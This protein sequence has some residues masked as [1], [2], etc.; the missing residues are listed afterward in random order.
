MKSLL[1]SLTL[2][3]IPVFVTSSDVDTQ[4]GFAYVC[5][6][7]DGKPYTLQSCIE[8]KE[9]CKNEL[10][11]RDMINSGTAIYKKSI[12]HF[13]SWDD[14]IC[15]DVNKPAFDIFQEETLWKFFKS[16][17]AKQSVKFI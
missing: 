2:M 13:G 16:E 14:G 17:M 11:R 7:C 3:H 8:E 9:V 15:G 6:N 10:T 12:K 4:N 5:F 1:T